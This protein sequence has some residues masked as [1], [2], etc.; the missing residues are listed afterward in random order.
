MSKVMNFELVS[1]E[2]KLVSEPMYQVEIPGDDGAFGVMAGH[3]SILSSLRAGVVT[4]H[5]E[6]GSSDNRRIF[7]NGGFADVSAENCTILAEEAIDV[8]DLS[9]ESLEQ[10]LTDLNED[11]GIAEEIHDKKHIEDNIALTKAKLAA[12]AI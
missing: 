12:V 8:A 7:I 11:L 3:C 4:L 9:K 10:Y 5:K 2:A 6:E 1:P